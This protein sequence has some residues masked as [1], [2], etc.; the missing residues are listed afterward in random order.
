MR[1]AQDASQAVKKVKT[2]L[3]EENMYDF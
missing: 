2:P 1:K 3:D